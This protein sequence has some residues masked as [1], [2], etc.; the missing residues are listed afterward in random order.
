MRRSCQSAGRLSQSVCT[1][2]CGIARH[3]M[4]S[5]RPALLS[6][7]RSSPVGVPLGGHRLQSTE[8]STCEVT[9][10]VCDFLE[11]SNSVLLD[12]RTA[13]EL[14]AISVP[15]AI[16]IPLQELPARVNELPRGA[17]V[18]VFCAAGVRSQMALPLLRSA[19]YH[20]EDCV[21]VGVVLAAC[22]LLKQE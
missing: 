14:S 1:R 2:T 15:G 20:A 10:R 22:D 9:E 13:E 11:M 4:A 8:S 18:G 5:T 12:V 6:A 19:G 16:H 17:A 3:W 7:W 21:S